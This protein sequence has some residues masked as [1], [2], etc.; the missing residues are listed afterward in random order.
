MFDAVVSSGDTTQGLISDV[1]GPIYFLGPE[2]DH[3]LLEGL[4]VTLAE[5]KDA[6][7]VR[8]FATTWGFKPFANRLEEHDSAL[9]K[10]MRDAGAI[11]IGH[12]NMPEF[13]LGSNTFNALFGATLNPYDTTK[14]AGGSSGGAAVALATDMLPLADHHHQY[15]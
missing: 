14:T 4:D 8:G 11:F 9:A 2:R 12:S 15:W 13:G 6:V 1:D 10:R 5:P 7:A 3:I